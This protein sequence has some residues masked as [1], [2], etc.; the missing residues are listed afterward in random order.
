MHNL[1][2]IQWANYGGL[3]K[4]CIGSVPDNRVNFNGVYPCML[5]RQSTLPTHLTLRTFAPLHRATRILKPP[6]HVSRILHLCASAVIPLV[7]AVRVPLGL[8]G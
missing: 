2:R 4:R 7:G 3:G 5:A 1:K 6:A 8:R